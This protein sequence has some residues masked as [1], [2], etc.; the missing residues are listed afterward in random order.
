LPLIFVKFADF[1]LEA[2]I[3]RH[4]SKVI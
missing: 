2:L 1:I 3:Q 4:L